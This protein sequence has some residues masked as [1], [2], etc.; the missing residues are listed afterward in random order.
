VVC[1]SAWTC[2]RCVERFPHSQ[3]LHPYKHHE[4]LKGPRGLSS[5]LAQFQGFKLIPAH[6]LPH[7]PLAFP[8]NFRWR[9]SANQ[10]A[11]QMRGEGLIYTRSK[12]QNP[13][14]QLLSSLFFIS[15][16]LQDIFTVASL[17]GSNLH[18]NLKKTETRAPNH[19][20]G[21]GSHCGIIPIHQETQPKYTRRTS[22]SL[23]AIA[24]I[25]L[26]ELPCVPASR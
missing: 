12:R 16:Y 5:I 7:V 19:Y 6:A 26:F 8:N 2:R 1:H 10:G 4:R 18:L 22:F 21:K 15:P 14:W 11:P 17:F 25:P 24:R 23:G 20:A 9:P 3:Q 13:H